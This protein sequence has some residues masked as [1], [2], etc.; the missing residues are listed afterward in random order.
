MTRLQTARTA[1]PIRRSPGSR[2]KSFLMHR[3]AFTGTW[4][5]FPLCVW[6]YVVRF[7]GPDG[8]ILGGC[9]VLAVWA[10]RDR[11][12]LPWLVWLLV[13]LL[14]ILNSRYR[15]LPGSPALYPEGMVIGDPVTRRL[16]RG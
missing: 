9:A 14:L 5:D 4:R 7:L 3:H 11:R 13:T 12:Q 10:S 1:S 6:P 2:K 15:V 16:P 8:M